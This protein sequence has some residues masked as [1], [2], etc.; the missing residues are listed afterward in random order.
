MNNGNKKY[1]GV[2][3]LC[4]DL[5]ISNINNLPHKMDWKYKTRKFVKICH[6]SNGNENNQC[7]NKV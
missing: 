2:N 7:E 1:F 3:I 6:K 5:Y 4:A